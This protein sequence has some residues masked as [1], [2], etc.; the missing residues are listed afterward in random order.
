MSMKRKFDKILIANRGEIA[1]RVM[2]SAQELGIKAVAIYEET[3]KDAFHIMRADEA[4]CIGSGPRKDYLN[5]D[6]I[7][8]GANLRYFFHSK[9]GGR[10]WGQ[11]QL[12]QNTYGDPCVLFGPDGRAYFAHLT[13]GWD[14]ITVRYSDDGGETWSSGVKLLGPSSDSARPGS[15]FRSSLQDKELPDSPGKKFTR[16]RLPAPGP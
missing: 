14:A 10:T 4:V 9:D 16:P 3:D 2:R 5:I 1:V 8:A 6:N 11:G 12:P 13:V 15:L 7:I